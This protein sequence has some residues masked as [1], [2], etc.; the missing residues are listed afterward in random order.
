MSPTQL[1]REG[2]YQREAGGT[3][4]YTA[5]GLVVPGAKD[6]TLRDRVPAVQVGG[7]VHGAVWVSR[8]LALTEP[9][10]QALL[11]GLDA[12]PGSFGLPHPVEGL[13]EDTPSVIILSVGFW[14]EHAG[15]VI[16]IDAPELH[17]GAV[18]VIDEAARAVGLTSDSLMEYVRRG[19][20]PQPPVRLGRTPAW[21][22][23]VVQQWISQRRAP[24]VKCEGCGEP[25]EVLGLMARTADGVP[26]T[27]PLCPSCGERITRI[28]PGQPHPWTVSLVKQLLSST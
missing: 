14:N 22:R 23:P 4:R 18:L 1:F 5:T 3:W 21:P 27:I 9:H 28:L 13:P 25:T 19:T 2:V 26:Y 6:V 20:F 8:P 15:D 11:S 17:P 24:T 16:D 12:P 10:M 7:P